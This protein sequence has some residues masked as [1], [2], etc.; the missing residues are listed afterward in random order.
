MTIAAARALRNE[1]VCFVGIGMPSAACNL[2]RLTHA[3]DITLIYES[4]TIAH[5]AGR[6]AALDRRRRTVRDRA[7]HRVGAGDV[8]LLAAGRAH[9]RRLPRR[10]ADRPLRQPQHHGGRPLRQA[11]GAAA[12]RRR[13]AGDRDRLRRDLHHHGAGASA[14]SSTSST[15]SPRSATARAATTAPGSASRPRARP[16]SSPISAIFE[17]DPRDARK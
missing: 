6:A 1:D 11:E 9:H 12:G 10:R 4:G 8:P 13:R 14:A 17:P 2:A 16:S 3:P 15:S 7:D 5:Q